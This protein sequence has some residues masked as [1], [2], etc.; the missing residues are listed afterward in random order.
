MQW[1]EATSDALAALRTLMLNSS[2]DQ[3]SA[4][5]PRTSCASRSAQ[6]A[7]R[8]Y[9][10]P[11]IRVYARCTAS[12]ADARSMRPRYSSACQI[13]LLRADIPQFELTLDRDPWQ[14]LRTG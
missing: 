2:W 11:C 9:S 12:P 13:A 4:A 7:S 1:S 6:A 5:F 10:R 14:M 8:P 3:R